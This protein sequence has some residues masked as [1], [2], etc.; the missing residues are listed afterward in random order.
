MHNEQIQWLL[1]LENAGEERPAG[2]VN[3]CSAQA[4][5]L[6]EAI[7]SAI[8]VAMVTPGVQ[9]MNSMKLVSPSRAFFPL[10]TFLISLRNSEV[11]TD[12]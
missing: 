6:T 11:E 8:Y 2:D 1:E 5:L 7:R 10:S 4:A 9:H 12:Y 3:C